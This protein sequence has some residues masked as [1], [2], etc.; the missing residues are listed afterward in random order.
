MRE[1]IKDINRLQEGDFISLF[2][3]GDIIAGY[4]PLLIINK[5]KDNVVGVNHGGSVYRINEGDDVLLD[6]PSHYVEDV[7]FRKIKQF[8]DNLIELK[9]KY[10]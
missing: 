3:K 2:V 7:Y 10:K 5:D 9:D 1:K 8:I 6:I 4:M